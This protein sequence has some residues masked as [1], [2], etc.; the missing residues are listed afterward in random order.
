MLSCCSPNDSSVGTAV[1]EAGSAPALEPDRVATGSCFDSCM[2]TVNDAW[3]GPAPVG[4]KT[5]L[6]SQDSPAAISRYRQVLEVTT[7]SAPFGP[8]VRKPSKWTGVSP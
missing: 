7:N 6:A 1:G 8:D 5:T 2:S 3:R 4:V